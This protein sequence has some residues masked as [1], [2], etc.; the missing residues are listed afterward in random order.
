MFTALPLSKPSAPSALAPSHTLLT[1]LNTAGQAPNNALNN[2]LNTGRAGNE[3]AR[4]MDRAQDR[5]QPLS[6]QPPAPPSRSPQP[7]ASSVKA[8]AP[9]RPEGFAREAQAPSAQPN[10][11]PSSRPP[12]HNAATK[13]AQGGA[14]DAQRDSRAQSPSHPPA[15]GSTDGP[16]PAT[17]RAARARSAAEDGPT[18]VAPAGAMALAATL[19]DKSAPMSQGAATGIGLDRAWAGTAGPTDATAGALAHGDASGTGRGT[20][21][22]GGEVVNPAAGRTDVLSGQSGRSAM[23]GPT[24][25]GTGIPANGGL[26]GHSGSAGRGTIDGP[27]GP[28]GR[29]GQNG[30]IGPIGPNGANAVANADPSM[31]PGGLVRVDDNIGNADDSQPGGALPHLR[32]TGPVR[33][34]RIAPHLVDQLGAAPLAPATALAAESDVAA[35]PT[36]TTTPITSLNT[37]PNQPPANNP[38]TLE[39]SPAGAWRFVLQRPEPNAT[40]AYHPA[41]IS[42]L[43]SAIGAMNGLGQD[44]RSR[45]AFSP[46]APT[47]AAPPAA[48]AAGAESAALTSL[49]ALLGGT[50]RAE[51]AERAE[52]GGPSLPADTAAPAPGTSAQAMLATTATDWQRSA[53]VPGVVQ[54]QDG[55]PG[56]FSARAPGTPA[57]SLLPASAAQ[58]GALNEPGTTGLP[59]FATSLA[60]QLSSSISAVDSS[61]NARPASAEFA[62]EVSQKIMLLVLDGV[63]TAKLH[64]NPAEMGPVTVQIQ[65]DGATAQVHLAA[66]NG[67]TRQALQDSMPQLAS[68][69]RESGLTLTGG[70]VFEQ[71]RQTPQEPPPDQRTAQPD[72]KERTRDSAGDTN[73]AQNLR[74][75]G[76]GGT[77]ARRG[78]VDLVA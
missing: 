20:A 34:Y 50:D 21:T 33:E 57:E 18:D 45:Q 44:Q 4:A 77:G 27:T 19:P 52:R 68:Q 58:P 11:A 76:P 8:S 5:Q 36:P 7:P 67:D 59:N 55:G 56:D 69:L 38:T 46:F 71:P 74:A 47:P 3:F 1:S 65:L 2:A 64:L 70:G 61:V 22:A 48:G 62:A 32:N 39:A 42:A 60:T 9:K 12:Q 72:G 29:N 6:P 51:R 35:T 43:G 13:S 25:I 63:Q 75:G 28:T 40:D 10:A 15:A 31:A 54:R 49:A 66:E 24:R 14:R 23:E 16:T 53:K 30:S 26:R 78:L 73:P 41:S 17:R 37:A